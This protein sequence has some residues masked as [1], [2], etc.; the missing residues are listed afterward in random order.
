MGPPMS[1]PTLQEQELIIRAEIKKLEQQEAPLMREA[2]QEQDEVRK[3]LA[4]HTLGLLYKEIMT[5]YRELGRIKDAQI[6][7][8]RLAL[9]LRGG[10]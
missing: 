1:T 10:V 8:M 3:M 6:K 9:R 5:K 7:A 2:E 4:M